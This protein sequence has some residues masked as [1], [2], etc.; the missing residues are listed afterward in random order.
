MTNTH[1]TSCFCTLISVI[2][3]TLSH[4]RK[5]EFCLRW[6]PVG[7][8]WPLMALGLHWKAAK[9]WWEKKTKT[10]LMNHQRCQIIYIYR[11]NAV[12]TQNLACIKKRKKKNW[13]RFPVKLP[14]YVAATLSH[15]EKY[16]QGKLLIWHFSQM[17]TLFITQVNA[18]VVFVFFPCG[19]LSIFVH[20]AKTGF[21]P[22]WRRKPR[23]CLCSAEST[24][25]SVLIKSSL[26]A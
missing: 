10:I 3:P 2:I 4:S 25:C 6:L 11:P 8:L 18:F 1:L 24:V 17:R 21:F 15:N 22:Q 14:C 19:I 5:F 23:V 13:H 7:P 12:K 20:Q 9:I 26:K 16:V